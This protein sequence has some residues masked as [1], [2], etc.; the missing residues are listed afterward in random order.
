[1]IITIE[2]HSE[3]QAEEFRAFFLSQQRE[4][5]F[6]LSQRSETMT[7]N[8]RPI[9]GKMTEEFRSRCVY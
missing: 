4:D 2:F 3:D 8:M 1:M 6:S 9:C 5:E 7:K